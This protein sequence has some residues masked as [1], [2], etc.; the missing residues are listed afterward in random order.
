MEDHVG[1]GRVIMETE[2]MSEGH[3]GKAVVLRMLC[4]EMKNHNDFS[5]LEHVAQTLSLAEQTPDIVNQD[6]VEEVFGQCKDC[7]D[8][9]PIAHHFAR[10]MD[11][12]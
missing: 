12:Q 10:M 1:G 7:Y 3:F 4:R 5:R 6:Y 8:D 9:C 11:R 2:T